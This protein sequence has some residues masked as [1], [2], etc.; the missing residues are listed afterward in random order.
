MQKL[1]GRLRSCEFGES[2]K[3]TM[4]ACIEIVELDRDKSRADLAPLLKELHFTQKR[5]GQLCR[6][7]SDSRLM[8]YH[9]NL[10]PSVTALYALSTL[11]NSEL[12]DGILTGQLNQSTSSRQIYAYARECRLRDIAFSD[13]AHLQPCY[14]AFSAKGKDLGSQEIEDLLKEAN[15]KLTKSGIMIIQSVSSTSKFDDKQ[16]ELIDKEKKQGKIETEIEHQMYM[17]SGDLSKHFSVEKIDQIMESEMSRFVRALSSVSRSR[18]DMM[19]TH[20]HLYCYKIALEYHR[21][22]SRVQKYNYKR[23]LIHVQ[24]KYEFLSPVVDSIF[25]EL[26]ERPRKAK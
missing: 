26:V 20:G 12:T 13:T 15:K 19:R 18:V 10:P 4:L 21:T 1:L 2:A 8:R 25:T 22:S 6:I 7:G 3:A 14:L 23:R 11:T 9:A 16:K 24:H 5:W 17:A